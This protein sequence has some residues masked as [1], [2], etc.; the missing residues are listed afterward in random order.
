MFFPDTNGQIH[1]DG[2]EVGGHELLIEWFYKSTK[3]FLVRD[4][5]N[6]IAATT[7]PERR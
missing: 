4:H 3:L 6:V 1:P 7:S 2:N 5:G